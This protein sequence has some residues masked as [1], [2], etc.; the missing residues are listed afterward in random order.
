MKHVT[1]LLLFAA[2]ACSSTRSPI[3]SGQLNGASGIAATSAGDRDLLFV[4]N[5]GGDE[6]RA[7]N[8]CTAADGGQRD[9]NDPCPLTEDYQ[10]VSGPIRL[11][12]ASIQANDRPVRLAGARLTWS[13]GN[14][15]AV[16]VAGAESALRVV[17]AKNIVDQEERGAPPADAGM[18]PLAA[19][20]T[21]VVA[22]NQLD[23]GLEVGAASVFAFAVV[24]KSAAAPA[25]LVVLNLHADPG[26]G[27]IRLS[28]QD[29]VGSCSLDPVQPR[30]IALVPGRDDVVYIADG[31]G[32]GVVK[33]NRADVPAGAAAASTCPVTRLSAGGR[34]T[35]SVAASPAFTEQSSFG[36]ATVVPH[37]AGDFL[38]VA[39]DDS[40]L[41]RVADPLSSAGCGGILILSTATGTV[42]GQPTAGIYAAGAP[43]MA[44]LVP[45]LAFASVDQ[46]S[47][48]RD[49]AF[50]Q[51][52]A[53]GDGCK[54]TSR[55]NTTEPC[56]ELIVGGNSNSSKVP[57]PFDLIAVAT[58]TDGGDYFI[59]VVNR[60]FVNDLRD[61]PA[62]LSLAPTVDA[63]GTL[64]PAALTT[65]TNPATLTPLK[66]P[67]DP[68]HP[69]DPAPTGMTLDGWV[70]PGVTRRS[71][72]RAVFHGPFNGLER[73]GG[74]L[75]ASGH[76]TYNFTVA[77]AD[78][79]RWKNATL[80]QLSPGDAVALIFPGTPA[81]RC[82][83]LAAETIA[84][85]LELPIVSISDSVI[86]LAPVPDGATPGFHPADSCFAAP[87]GVVAEVRAA[88]GGGGRPWLVYE[89]QEVRGRAKNGEN[90]V[91][92]EARTDYPG[93]CTNS[94][95]CG[96]PYSAPDPAA[97]GAAARPPVDI[98]VAFVISGNDPPLQSVLSFATNSVAFPTTVR[99]PALA[100]GLSDS[101]FVY[102]SP[103][104]Q[105]L[106]FTSVTGGN[107]LL[108]ANPLL[109]NVPGGIVSY[110]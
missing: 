21:D 71:R 52:F 92:R 53:G 13:G 3:A 70:N 30:K 102:H 63:V 29:I 8:I 104:V 5:A 84:L 32:D 57:T 97:P 41:C 14:T 20:A 99:D 79:A 51:P 9:Q 73:R 58:A 72:W 94:S 44:P 100:G 49:V 45:R 17:D 26:T 110:R 95:V 89:N 50:L 25:Q 1:P 85:R 108:Q 43:P 22:G 54:D 55:R 12:P 56:T 65:E 109:L 91:A 15:G 106:I 101:V 38:V 39:A 40:P 61:V 62:G 59:D 46:L 76:G 37:P 67:V 105:N 80:L 34:P 4:A 107:G 77:P 74:S 23:G 81:T 36:V 16:L 98:A 93:A 103:K 78:L 87:V 60:R 31:A 83:D 47:F 2:A 82:P 10:F 48:V 24:E 68:A 96:I 66:P 28:A 86:E 11:F 88:N 27:A 6:L 7:L 42:V 75:T 19:P 35:R 64:T 90:F 33:V 69:T 18:V